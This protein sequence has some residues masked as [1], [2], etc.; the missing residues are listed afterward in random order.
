M[1]LG[2][3]SLAVTQLMRSLS[4]SLE[5]NLSPQC[6]LTTPLWMHWLPI[7]LSCS[8]IVTRKI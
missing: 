3:D 7:S 1:D 5:V 4:E 2:L 8:L 6:F